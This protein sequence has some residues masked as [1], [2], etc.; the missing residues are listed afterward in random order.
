MFTSENVQGMKHAVDGLGA[1][2]VVTALL[3][4]MPQ[5]AALFAVIWYCIQMFDNFKKK[6]TARKARS[7]RAS[8]K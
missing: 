3:G 5:I 7:R 6:W 2:V 8:D 1:A 4:Y